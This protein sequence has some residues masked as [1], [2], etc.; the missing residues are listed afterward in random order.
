MVRCGRPALLWGFGMVCEFIPICGRGAVRVGRPCPFFGWDVAMYGR[1]CPFVDEM[2][3]FGRPRPI[4]DGLGRFG[5][6]SP[7][8]GPVIRLR[9]PSPFADGLWRGLGV[10]FLYGGSVGRLGDHCLLR[11]YCGKVRL[12]MSFLEGAW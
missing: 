6:S 8:V 7:F 1:P 11:R 12:S 10:H 2:G 9:R 5:R 3:R 4:L